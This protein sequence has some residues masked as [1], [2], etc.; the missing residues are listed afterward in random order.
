MYKTTKYTVIVILANILTCILSDFWVHFVVVNFIISQLSLK[1]NPMIMKCNNHFKHN[2][3][4][5]AK[6]NCRKLS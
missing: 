4:C 1:W 6:V 5:E 2:N 3:L